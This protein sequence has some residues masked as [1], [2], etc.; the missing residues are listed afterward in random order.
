MRSWLKEQFG[1]RVRIEDIDRVP[2]GSAARY[3]L[4]AG[5]D[6]SKTV[7]A[8]LALAKR[9]VPL[10]DAK[11]AVEALLDNREVGVQI[12]KLENAA[13]FEGELAALGIRALQMGTADQLGACE[14]IAS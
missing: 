4:R 2:S 8:A 3:L 7:S 11:A 6:F 10:A 1:H 12:P 14:R 9:H 13:R 5:P